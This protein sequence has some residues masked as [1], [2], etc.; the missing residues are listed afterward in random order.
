MEVD[1]GS[2]KDEEED[3]ARDDVGALAGQQT[4]G[5]KEPVRARHTSVNV[6][7][8]KTSALVGPLAAAK[9][10]LPFEESE[11]YKTQEKNKRMARLVNM[12]DGDEDF[13]IGLRDKQMS[14]VRSRR[15]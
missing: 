4:V 13:S 6:E 8:F 12:E 2:G 3:E 15:N 7:A 5:R 11:W 10:A 1:S 14:Y 9:K